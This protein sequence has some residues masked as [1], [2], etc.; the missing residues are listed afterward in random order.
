MEG[1]RYDLSF[2]QVPVTK[3]AASRDGLA[4][5]AEVEANAHLLPPTTR[6]VWIDGG[7]HSQF[8]WYGFQPGDR[9]A[10]LPRA[11]QQRATIAAMLSVLRQVA[12]LAE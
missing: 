5:R 10:E 11:A 4:S 6:W 8:A 12:D 9:P 1:S 7:N 2:L 3:V